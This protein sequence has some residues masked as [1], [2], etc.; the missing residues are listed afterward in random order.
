MTLLEDCQAHFDSS[1]IYEIF[2]V[3]EKDRKSLTTSKLKKLYY[4]LALVF[5]PDKNSGK[6]KKQQDLA[7]KKFQI[8]GKIHK[9]LSTP[10]LKDLYDE[11]GEIVDE[12]A[13]DLFGK[14]ETDQEWSDYWRTL[15]P[16][17]TVSKL[18]EFEKEYKNSSEELTDLKASYIENK[19][20]MD[21]IMDSIMFSRLEDEDRFANIF[22]SLI[23]GKEVDDFKS[24]SSESETKKSTRRKRY[25]EE[26][27]EAE[28]HSK[29]LDKSKNTTKK[30]KN[31]KA[32]NDDDSFDLVAVMQKRN[33]ERRVQG[34]A[35]LA[36]LEAK[37]CQ[38]S[39]KKSKK[40]KNSK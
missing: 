13:N 3:P 40:G 12:D 15:Y 14:S 26:E 34:E 28:E 25:Q 31:G 29:F 24:F 18:K 17:V 8:L 23:Q 4:K 22:N 35:F 36:G 7:T 33:A 10:E 16:K 27:V 38:P 37:Y 21:K 19:G 5:H 30:R 2:N 32:K 20:D 1:D 11:T 6:S 39:P 9:I